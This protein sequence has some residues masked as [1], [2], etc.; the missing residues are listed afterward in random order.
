MRGKETF[1]SFLKGVA[2]YREQASIETYLF[3]ILR[4][5]EMASRLAREV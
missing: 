1:I 4:W 3:G 5:V 2:E